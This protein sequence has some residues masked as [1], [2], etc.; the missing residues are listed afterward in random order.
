MSSAGK[1]SR[2]LATIVFTDAVNFSARMAEDESHTVALIHRDLRYITN[3][4]EKHHGRVLKN[5]GDGLLM[6]FTTAGDAVACALRV[7]EAFAKAAETQGVDHCLQHR[8]GIHLGDVFLNDNDVLGDGVN[9]AARLL[10]EAEP[11]GICF[12]QTV[13]DVVKHR[14][15]LQAT[16]LGPRELKHIREAVP[17]YQIIVATALK[18][19]AEPQ[20][21]AAS[22]RPAARDFL[23]GLLKGKGVMGKCFYGI[24]AA[25]F[26][27]FVFLSFLNTPRALAGPQPV[28]APAAQNKAEATINRLF[29]DDLERKDA[30][31]RRDLATRLM[32]QGEATT[33]DTALRYVCYRKSRDLAAGAGDMDAAIISINALTRDF[34]LDLSDVQKMKATAFLAAAPQATTPEANVALTQT[35]LELVGALMATEN[36]LDADRVLPV[37]IAAAAKTKQLPLVSAVDAKRAEMAEVQKLRLA[38]ETLK[39][40][41]DDPQAN[42]LVGRHLALAKGEWAAALPLLAKCPEGPLNDLAIVELAGP[43]DAAAQLKLANSWWDAGEKLAEPGKASVRKHAMVWYDKSWVGLTAGQRDELASRLPKELVEQLK[44]GGAKATEVDGHRVLD[45]M[46]LVKGEIERNACPGWNAENGSVA[47]NKQQ[48]LLFGT[49]YRPPDEYDFHIEFTR[50][51]GNDSVVQTLAHGTR[52]FMWQMGTLINTG[53]RFAVIRGGSGDKNPTLARVER[54]IENGRRY[55]AIVRVRRG[56]VSGWLDGQLISTYKTDYSDLSLE[57]AWAA[58]SDELGIGSHMSATTFHKIEVTEITGRGEVMCRSTP[59]VRQLRSFVVPRAEYVSLS[60]NAHWFVAGSKSRNGTAGSWLLI[61]MDDSQ[62]IRQYGG[63]GACLSPNGQY[64]CASKG[65]RPCF[66]DVASGKQLCEELAGTLFSASFSPD[67]R[68]VAIGLDS[69]EMVIWDMQGQMELRRFAGLPGVPEKLAFA[70]NS[71]CFVSGSLNDSTVILWDA[72]QPQELW[73][74]SLD[75]GIARVAFSRDGA[76]ILANRAHGDCANLLSAKDG[77]ILATLSHTKGRVYATFTPDGRF[78]FSGGGEEDC[79]LKLWDAAKGTDLDRFTQKT[80]PVTSVA[81]SSDGRRA[82][83]GC[84]DGALRLFEIATGKQLTTFTGHDG[85]IV[86]VTFSADGKLAATACDDGYARIFKLPE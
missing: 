81:V 50:R 60:E 84:K 51:D 59:D 6:Y 80:G 28:P 32:E 62:L 34:V 14:L 61:A 5:T 53:H 73:R 17:V 24:I 46:P 19:T 25:A 11:G 55:S 33:N 69:K 2:V 70:P 65:Y 23:V 49:R 29:R 7:Q 58:G 41:P 85:A 78:V 54:A 35:G 47:S 45:L 8:I 56:E 31:S 9:I 83:A 15:G 3:S 77:K 52:R 64:I 71:R 43:A 37:L 21:D 79:A 26:A 22:P 38:R 66:F 40:K 76:L 10:G 1:Q 27:A 67:G 13:Y 57:G 18:Q 72:Q 4:C 36:Y 82:L 44:L 75:R 86:D 30:K 63:Y 12:S 68:R 48:Y 16:Y 39:R 42:L 20:S 74:A